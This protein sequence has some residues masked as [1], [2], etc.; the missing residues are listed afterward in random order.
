[1]GCGSSTVGDQ[2]RALQQQQQ[3]QQNQAVGQINQAFAGFDPTFYKGIQNAYQNFATPQLYQQYQPIANQTNYKLA[4]QGLTGSSSDRYLHQQLGQEM[5]RA[6][7][8]IGNQGLAQS[9]QLQQQVGNEK[10]TLTNQA[11][12]SSNPQSIAGQALGQASQF[13]APSAF[14]PIG[15]LLN[16]F[17]TMYLGQQSANTYNQFANQYLNQ[18]NNSG[19]GFNSAIP[20]PGY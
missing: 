19:I 9:Q 7:Q 5:G 14:Q 13:Q 6:Q 4:N 18:N 8:T 15:N 10:A 2:S 1:M 17:A 3:A 20:Q 16:N 11:I 12:S